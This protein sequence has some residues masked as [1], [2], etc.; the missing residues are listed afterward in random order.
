MTRSGFSWVSLARAIRPL[1]AVADHLQRGSNQRV[2]HQPP[3]DHRVID[4]QHADLR[5]ALYY[6]G[7]RAV[8]ASR[9][10][11]VVNGFIRYSLAPA[12]KGPGDLL[13]LRLGRH[14]HQC[15]SQS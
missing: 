7:V 10:A 3:D 5:H 15:A 4:N 2:G 11:S 8:R 12:L 9:R 6:P 14:H 13:D 1:G